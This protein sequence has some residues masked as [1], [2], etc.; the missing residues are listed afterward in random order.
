MPP[1]FAKYRAESRRIMEKLRALT[2]LVQPL[3]LDEAWLDLSGTERLHGGAAGRD[4]GAAAGRDR[5]RGRHHRLDRPGGQQVPGQDRLGPR[6][7][8]RLRGDRRGGGARPSWRRGRSSILPGVGPAFAKTLEQRRLRARSATSPR[9]EPKRPGRPL[10]RPR[11]A[12]APAGA[13]PRRPRRQSATRAARAFAPRPPS[14]TTSATLADLEDVLWPLCE[15][16]ARHARGEAIAGRVVT[17]KLRATDFRIVTRRRTLPFADPD[18][19]HAVR[20]GARNAGRRGARRGPG[21]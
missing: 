14:T 12:P 11:P 8:A 2:P 13:R 17:L 1:D 3:S 18:R 15:K 6:Q 16:V 10:R 20:R 21:G 7:A 9:A 5:A 4:A 19:P